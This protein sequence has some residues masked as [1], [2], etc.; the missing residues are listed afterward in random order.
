MKAAI[1]EDSPPVA[2]LLK[3]NL[4]EAFPEM[5]IAG[6]ADS[7]P[8][9]LGLIRDTQPD[10][11][12][13][14]IQIKQGT[15]FGLLRALKAEGLL[16]AHLI[17]VTG[18]GGRDNIRKALQYAALDFIDKPIDAEQLRRAVE[19]AYQRDSDQQAIIEKLNRMEELLSQAGE[20]QRPILPVPILNGGIEMVLKSQVLYLESKGPSCLLHLQGGRRVASSCHLKHFEEQMGEAEGFYRISQTYLVNE[21]HIQRYDP[22][23]KYLTLRN[24]TAL[25]AS[26]RKGAEFYRKLNGA[27]PDDKTTLRSLLEMLRQMVGR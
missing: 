14:D 2:E 5:A 3:E 7:L 22:A 20:Q 4:R 9:A 26:R 27:A 19:M 17:F 12:F 10:L 16:N 15:A 1:I 11:L 25:R 23:E 6:V 24:G 21:L 18:H 13:L 8:G